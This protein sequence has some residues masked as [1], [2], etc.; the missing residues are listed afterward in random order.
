[1]NKFCKHCGHEQSQKNKFCVECGEVPYNYV[2]PDEYR[3]EIL[4]IE[5]SYKKKFFI[6]GIILIL[7]SLIILIETLLIYR[8]IPAGKDFPLAIN[9]INFIIY[10]FAGFWMLKKK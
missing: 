5:N 2:D 10:L 4:K 8:I 6:I 1:M 3:M 7:F 9:G